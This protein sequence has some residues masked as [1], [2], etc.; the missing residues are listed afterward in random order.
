MCESFSYD[1]GSHGGL[2]RT[3]NKQSGSIKGEEYVQR[4][5]EENVFKRLNTKINL[6]YTDSVC[7]AQ[8]TQCDSIIKINQ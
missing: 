3:R 6:Y 7:S 1:F 4:L 2:L 5:S 8:R